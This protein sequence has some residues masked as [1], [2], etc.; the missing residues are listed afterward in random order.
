MRR[1]IIII[2][3]HKTVPKQVIDT[4]IAVSTRTKICCNYHENLNMQK[5]LKASTNQKQFPK[6]P[7]PRLMIG[8][9]MIDLFISGDYL[10]ETRRY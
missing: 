4:K 8:M 9:K 7:E 2:I 1:T 10:N 5:T 3:I 6:R